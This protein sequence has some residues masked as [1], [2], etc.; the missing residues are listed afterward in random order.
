MQ[1]IDK[2]PIIDS[3]VKRAFSKIYHQQG[4]TLN[5]PDQTVEFILGEKNNYHQS[6]TSYL[7]FEVTVRNLAAS[8]DNTSQIRLMKNPYALCFKEA[9]LATTG[10]MEFQHVKFLGQV[11]SIM[12]A[13]TSEDGDFLSHFDKVFEGYTA[14][15]FNS[16]S[17]KQ[18]LFDNHTVEVNKGKTKGQL[19]L[20]HKFGFCKTFK[21]INKN[22]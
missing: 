7:E 10:G 5:N 18:T 3:I 4:A 19:P 15:D 12:G 16:T 2:E 21:K 13:L 8:S 22:L 20:G 14:A 17:L 11:S 9:S 6:G 1:L